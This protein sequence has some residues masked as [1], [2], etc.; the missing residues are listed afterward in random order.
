M[1]GHERLFSQAGAT[2]LAT[3]PIEARLPRNARQFSELQATQRVTIQ[4]ETGD[5]GGRR[6]AAGGVDGRRYLQ[7]TVV[8]ARSGDGQP[9]QPT[10]YE[11]PAIGMSRRS[12]ETCAC[13]SWSDFEI[14]PHQAPT[15]S[16]SRCWRRSPSL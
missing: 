12:V 11:S 13:V 1:H 5:G 15:S 7:A 16:A 8:R 2:C 3:A 6:G 9:P 4:F 14:A 10:R